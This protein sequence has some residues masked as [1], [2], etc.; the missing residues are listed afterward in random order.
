[1]HTSLTDGVGVVR[2][3]TPSSYLEMPISARARWVVQTLSDFNLGSRPGAQFVASF[4]RLKCLPP[5]SGRQ[6]PQHRQTIG[7]VSIA[8]V[9]GDPQARWGRNYAGPTPC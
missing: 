9:S 8:V 1:M 4:R 7:S 2:W 5:H 6:K 3:S